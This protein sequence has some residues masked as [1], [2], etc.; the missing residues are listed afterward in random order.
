MIL[1]VQHASKAERSLGAFLLVIFAMVREELGAVL[2]PVPQVVFLSGRQILG[3]PRVEGGSA[4]SHTDADE[5]IAYQRFG[6]HVVSIA[7]IF[8]I[9]LTLPDQAHAV[10][11]VL[12][13]SR[14]L[15]LL[16]LVPQIP[17]LLVEA[18]RVHVDVRALHGRVECRQR[19]RPDAAVAESARAMRA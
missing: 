16:L 7:H 1:S 13:P 17:R 15:L 3:C 14:D 18:L 10:D 2:L 8:S 11:H 9:L 5:C 6:P 19:R 4:P 12:V